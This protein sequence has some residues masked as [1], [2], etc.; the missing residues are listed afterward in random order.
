MPTSIPPKFIIPA[1]DPDMRGEIDTEHDLEYYGK[2]FLQSLIAYWKAYEDELI[3]GIQNSKSSLHSP[4][5]FESLVANGRVTQSECSGGFSTDK[6]SHEYDI[7]I[8]CIALLQ[9][10]CENAE[11]KPCI[12][13]YRPRNYFKQQDKE[14]VVF[15]D[16]DG[17]VGGSSNYIG[18]QITRI[19]HIT[20]QPELLSILL[21][22]PVFVA[23]N[24]NGI[25]KSRNLKVNATSPEILH[26]R[27][28]AY[29]RN[30]PDFRMKWMRTLSA[31]FCLKIWRDL[32]SLEELQNVIFNYWEE[33][34]MQ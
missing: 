19:T 24:L 23:G 22:Q 34:D 18:G 2:S 17:V 33:D 8:D 32:F 12:P 30:N 7:A 9:K 28:I 6:L 20:G 10:I 14:I 11:E 15:V 29:F 16:Y 26:S 3:V 27:E 4:I 25:K 1:S 13:K 31:N 5:T 21:S